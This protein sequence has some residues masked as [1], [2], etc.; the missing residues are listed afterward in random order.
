MV[1]TFYKYE[2]NGF[3]KIPFVEAGIKAGFP[4]PAEDFQG[5]RIS[6]DKELVK[7][8]TAT[9]YAKV[10]GDSMQDA[11]MSDGDLLV[12]DRSLEPQ[13]GKIAVCML[14]GDFTVKRLRVDK[15]GVY[16]VPENKSYQEIKVGED[17]ELVIWGIV[18]YVIKKV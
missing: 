16:L 4:S 8:E 11:G 5:K 10:D 12:I 14:D 9:F 6:L 17:Q 1:L 2:S 3:V 18:T 15:D 13:N 7:N